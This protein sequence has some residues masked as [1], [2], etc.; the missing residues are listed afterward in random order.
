MNKKFQGLE[1]DT[2]FKQP[3]KWIFQKFA[4]GNILY[5]CLLVSCDT[6]PYQ[7]A[8]RRGVLLFL[9]PR[10]DI[11]CVSARHESD[12]SITSPYQTS[13]VRQNVQL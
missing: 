5:D 1:S 13:H 11:L 6:G 4:L 2:T 3:K 9:S 10:L 12:Q 7:F 8:F